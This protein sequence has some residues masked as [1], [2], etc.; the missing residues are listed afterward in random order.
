MVVTFDAAEMTVLVLALVL[1]VFAE[2]LA[3][4]HGIL[5]WVLLAFAVGAVMLVSL[6]QAEFLR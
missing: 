3:G 2:R 5:A 4:S 6:H 1:S